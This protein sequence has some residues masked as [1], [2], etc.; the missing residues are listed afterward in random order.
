MRPNHLRRLHARRIV[1]TISG[2]GVIGAFRLALMLR[3]D[4]RER[5]RRAKASRA[6]ARSG[7]AAAI[8]V[9]CVLCGLAAAAAQAPAVISGSVAYRE[10]VALSADAVLEITL[11]DVSLADA[12]ATVIAQRELTNIGQ[13]PITFEL[14]Y[15]PTR[16]VANHRYNVRFRLSDRGALRFMS[17]EAHPVITGG[18]GTTVAAILHAVVVTPPVTQAA[19]PFQDRTWRL[20]R[21]GDRPVNVSPGPREPHLRFEST[22]SRVQGATGCNTVAGGYTVD[23]ETLTFQPLIATRMHCP[24]TMEI[25]QGLLKA[26]GATRSWR[27]AKGRMELLGEQNQVLAQFE[28]IEPK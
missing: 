6:T 7:P 23:G 21:L 3:P 13:V 8:G 12:P 1:Q 19:A 22:S 18:H 28:A 17:A 14:P 10:R 4:G 16:I 5:R 15:D 25:E 2:S 27:I 26:L 11:E 9:I 20:V 24:D